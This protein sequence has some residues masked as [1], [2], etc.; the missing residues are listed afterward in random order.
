MSTPQFSA[1]GLGREP[2]I[3][4]MDGST[5]AQSALREAVVL[6]EALG[7]RLEAV[8]VWQRS[9]SMSDSYHLEPGTSPKVVALEAAHAAARV[10]FGET[11]PSWFTVR[12]VE[13][14]PPETLVEASETASHLVV[15]SRGRGRVGSVFLGS[16]SLH[17]ASQAHCPVVV[18]GPDA[19]TGEHETRVIDDHPEP[20]A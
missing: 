13:G 7:R 5:S 3:V 1:W 15:G 9:T 4:G 12:A 14:S 19:L 11:W 17:C 16:V 20:T 18:V 2:V 6:A 8:C 10:E